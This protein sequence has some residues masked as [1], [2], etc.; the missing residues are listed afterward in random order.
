MFEG[1]LLIL[2]IAALGYASYRL[3]VAVA[4]KRFL[5]SGKEILEEIGDDDPEGLAKIW[6]METYMHKM[7][8]DKFREEDD[9]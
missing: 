4:E 9:K 8:P 7:F 3:G 6:V 1:I 2:W 5:N